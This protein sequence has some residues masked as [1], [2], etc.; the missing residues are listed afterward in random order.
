MA[1]VHAKKVLN[2]DI[3]TLWIYCPSRH[4]YNF[5]DIYSEQQGTSYCCTLSLSNTCNVYMQLLGLIM[6]EPFYVVN[7]LSWVVETCIYLQK[8]LPHRIKD[9]S[10]NPPI[11]SGYLFN[12][13]FLN[14]ES[15]NSLGMDGGRPSPLWSNTYPKN[16]IRKRH[17]S[18]KFSLCYFFYF[19]QPV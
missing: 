17:V 6:F 13:Y 14:P 8:T 2:I 12:H 5:C 4:G 18:I 3:E 10:E 16:E 11:V 15:D 1:L 19:I 7:T 9:S